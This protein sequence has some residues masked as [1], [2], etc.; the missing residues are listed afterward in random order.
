MMINDT[1]G[2][3]LGLFISGQ[4]NTQ[5]IAMIARET[6]N[7]NQAS[8]NLHIILSE[9]KG[10]RNVSAINMTV[11]SSRRTLERISITTP[12]S[13]PSAARIEP[14]WTGACVCTTFDEV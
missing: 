12:H 6:W 7:L 3:I 13:F 2:W 5:N 9:E 1:I 10:D 14:N 8:E 11:I 4:R